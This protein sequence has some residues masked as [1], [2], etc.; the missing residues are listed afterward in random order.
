MNDLISISFEQPSAG[1]L[2]VDFRYGEFHLD[3]W[4]SD[5][6][7]NPVEELYNAITQLQDNKVSTV[8]WWEEPGAVYFDFEKKG[9][10]TYLT[11]F[12]SEEDPFEPDIER[13]LLLTINGPT[14]QIT[15][16]FYAALKALCAKEPE[17]DDWLYDLNKIL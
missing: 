10:N 16:P 14:Q 15:E 9:N 1:W 13:K 5:R 7:N 12:E 2:P 4:A 8:T 3:F 6:I 11:I 17:E